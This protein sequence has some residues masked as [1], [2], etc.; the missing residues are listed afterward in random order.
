[1]PRKEYLSA[2][3]RLRFDSLPQLQDM[4]NLFEIPHWAETFENAHIRH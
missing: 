4:R 2:D 1:M 3:Q